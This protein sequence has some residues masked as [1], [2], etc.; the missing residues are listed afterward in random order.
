MDIKEQIERVVQTLSV[1]RT[2][3]EAFRL[4]PAE[5]VKKLVAIDLPADLV[6]KIVKG[7]QAKLAGDQ[8]ADVFSSIKKL[9]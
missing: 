6:D 1:D 9:F 4:S 8:A 5:I 3:H 7:V 2:L